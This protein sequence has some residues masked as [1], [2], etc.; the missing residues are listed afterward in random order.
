MV[1]CRVEAQPPLVLPSE[2]VVV[3]LGISYE[4][5]AEDQ[6]AFFT[7]GHAVAELSIHFLKLMFCISLTC[8]VPK[9]SL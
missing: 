8:I 4:V 7:G 2:A 9:L 1:L 6:E 3:A 5:L